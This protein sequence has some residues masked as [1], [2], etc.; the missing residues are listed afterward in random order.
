[1]NKPELKEG[2]IYA[3][4]IINPDGTGNHVILLAGDHEKTTWQAAM[5]W[6]KEQGGELPNRVESFLLFIQSKSEF[7]EYWYW[8]NETFAH[9]TEWALCQHFLNGGQ[10]Y[11]SKGCKLRAR[12][13]RRVSVIEF[14]SNRLRTYRRLIKEN[15]NE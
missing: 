4:A 11:T 3:G 15:V 12:A 6:A 1:M 14:T 9:D 5:D 8:T 2:E 10:H 13:V 7:E